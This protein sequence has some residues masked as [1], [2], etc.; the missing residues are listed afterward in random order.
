M[1]PGDTVDWA[2]VA[3]SETLAHIPYETRERAI[4]RLIGGGYVVGTDATTFGGWDCLDLRLTLLGAQEATGG[5]VASETIDERLARLHIEGSA[6]RSQ[7]TSGSLHHDQDFIAWRKRAQA[8]IDE[9]L[10]PESRSA[11][12]F[13]GLRFRYHRRVVSPSSPPISAQQHAG[14]FGADLNEALGILLAARDVTGIELAAGTGTPPPR[15]APLVQIEQI[16]HTVTGSASAD[17][18]VDVSVAELRQAIANAHGLSPD[19]RSEAMA[20]VPDDPKDMTVE[21]AARLLSVA[22][23][24][25]DL[26]KPVLGWLLANADQLPFF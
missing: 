25:K 6:F 22:T 16:G 13:A 7:G 12:E 3:A 11:R 15:S 8:A 24:A 10:G 23:K 2:N 26:F 5:L 4:R 21:K 1:A 20:S 19:E 18:H 14:V 9:K 17:V